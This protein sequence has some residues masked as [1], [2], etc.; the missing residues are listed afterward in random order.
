MKTNTNHLKLHLKGGPKPEIGKPAA[1]S[2]VA[3]CSRQLTHASSSSLLEMSP[4]GRKLLQAGWSELTSHL[5]SVILR[6][7][8]K[9]GG[10]PLPGLV[11]KKQSDS[12][13][14]KLGACVLVT[15]HSAV[16]GGVTKSQGHPL[17]STG[18]NS[19]GILPSLPLHPP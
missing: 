7:V 6:V 12:A 2:A 8:S 16:I 19:G 9:L 14:K 1:C 10:S 15:Q 11:H 13:M 3:Y 4:T 18:S 5:D 17:H